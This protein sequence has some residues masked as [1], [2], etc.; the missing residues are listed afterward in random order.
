MVIFNDFTYELGR[1]NEE[2]NKKNEARW[3]ALQI[4]DKFFRFKQ[5]MKDRLSQVSTKDLEY[6]HSVIDILESYNINISSNIHI[7]EKC[8]EEHYFLQ[9]KRLLKELGYY[10][11]KYGVKEDLSMYEINPFI[12]T[13]LLWLLL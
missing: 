2:F 5:L 8:Y 11:K 7:E 1:R 9:I 4:G 3:K 12:P 13:W 10:L 6:I